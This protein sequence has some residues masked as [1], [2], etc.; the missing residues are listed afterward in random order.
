M[1]VFQIIDLDRT[2]F[3]TKLFASAITDEINL[4]QPGLGTQ[5]DERFESAYQNEENFFLFR[6]L[7]QE[8]GDAWF[9]DVVQRAV[10]AVGRD[11]LAMPGFEA[12]IKGATKLTSHRPAWG[13][14]TYGDD[15]DQRLKLD[16]IG[17]TDA[18][19]LI[20]PTAS[21][22]ALIQSWQNADGSFT[23]PPE[24]GS[25][26]VSRIT[27]EDDK[28]RA[29]QDMPDGMIGV[30]ITANTPDSIQRLNEAVATGHTPTGIAIASGLQ[31]SLA[32]LSRQLG[33]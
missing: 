27:L 17:L 29:F 13:V 8:K 26:T 15:I 4:L 10:A 5:L 6:L 16:L 2:L 1:D 14:M 33:A 31:E 21:K 22:A 18:P 19:M 32:S 3:N 11:A 12:R 24:F 23:L 28:L 30:W 20:S 25:G 7:R 9:M